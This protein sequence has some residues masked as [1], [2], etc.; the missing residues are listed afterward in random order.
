MT[1]TDSTFG[2]VEKSVLSDQI[3]ERILQMVQERRLNP[4]DKLPPERELAAMMNVS[5]PALREALRGLS[6]MN[7]IEIRQGAGAFVTDLDPAQLV[8]HLNFVFALDDSTILELFDA[9]MIVEVGLIELAAQRITDE[10]IRLLE[11]NLERA[12][13]SADDIES[14]LQADLELHML[15]ARIARNPILARF[16]ESIQQLGLASRR[17]TAMIPGVAQRSTADHRRIVEALIRRDVAG[18]RQAM[19]D[20]LGNV[21]TKLRIISNGHEEDDGM[22]G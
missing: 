9:R 17:R 13:H 15:I 22:M 12:T 18:A 5:R 11:D 16:M 20:H 3:A 8:Q 19:L 2:K 21:E 4:G 1:L 7:I 6:M 10:D 14:F